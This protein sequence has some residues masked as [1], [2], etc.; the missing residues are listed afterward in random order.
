MNTP[1]PDI[2]AKVYLVPHGYQIDL[3]DSKGKELGSSCRDFG[4]SYPIKKMSV[5]VASGMLANMEKVEEVYQDVYPAKKG[6]KPKKVDPVKA[7]KA[8]S[9]MLRKAAHW[10]ASHNPGTPVPDWIDTALM[11]HELE[12]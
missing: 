5:I 10:F 12:R 7:L 4:G 6:K 1:K 11:L 2:T 8:K 3:L 9:A